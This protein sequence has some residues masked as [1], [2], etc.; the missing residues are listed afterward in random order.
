MNL[1]KAEIQVMADA[2]RGL[3]LR[4]SLTNEEKALLVKLEEF[5]E[6]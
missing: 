4:D 1:T 3:N 2:L 6:K 5:L